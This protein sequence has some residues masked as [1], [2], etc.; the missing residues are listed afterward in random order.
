MKFH[1]TFKSRLHMHHADY[2]GIPEGD[3][4]KISLLVC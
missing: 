1:K 2:N 3:G 4:K